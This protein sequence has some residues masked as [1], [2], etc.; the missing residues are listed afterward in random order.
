LTR[1]L[2]ES[3]G[4][5]CKTYLI[6]TI[7]P[8]V[9]AVEETLSTLSY[10]N[11]ANGI[12]NK[13]VT[14]AFMSGAASIS[15]LDKNVIIGE[16]GAA[17]VPSLQSWQE[18]EVRLA[19][20]TAQV[21]EAQQMLAQKHIENKE[22][23]E[24][25]E[26]AD[27]A[28]KVAEQTLEATTQRVTL[29]ETQLEETALRLNRTETVLNETTVLL[30][31]KH[32]SLV[33]KREDEIA[34][35]Q[36]TASYREE[37]MKL[38]QDLSNALTEIDKQ[39]TVLQT[40]LSASNMKQAKDVLARLD[41]HRSKVD[42]LKS[43]ADQS[44]QLR[45]TIHDGIIPF[46][47]SFSAQIKKDLGF[48]K[49]I[50]MDHS[51]TLQQECERIS[52]RLD[53]T[54][55][56]L[57]ESK[58]T[59]NGVSCAL[60]TDVETT[61]AVSKE[62]MSN[63][64]VGFEQMIAQASDDRS[65]RRTKLQETLG[66][67]KDTCHASMDT[68]QSL[69]Q[70]HVGNLHATISSLM[71][72][73]KSRADL[74]NHF[75]HHSKTLTDS[76]DEY[77]RRLEEQN[78]A[79]QLQCKTF[80]QLQKQQTEKSNQMV[81]NIMST[82]EGVV[83]KEAAEMLDLQRH[84]FEQIV[85][86]NTKMQS[87]NRNLSKRLAESFETFKA[88][89]SKVSL[90][91]KDLFDGQE[92]SFAILAEETDSF[93]ATMEGHVENIRTAFDGVAAESK[94]TIDGMHSEDL[95]STAKIV[96]ILSSSMGRHQNEWTVA[97]QGTV[98]SGIEALQDSLVEIVQKVQ[99]DLINNVR[100]DLA[101]GILALEASNVTNVNSSLEKM[102]ADV[103]GGERMIEQHS[104]RNLE[105]AMKMQKSIDDTHASMTESLAEHQQFIQES[106]WMETS[107]DNHNKTV[108]PTI[109]AAT[110][111]V[112]S[113]KNHLNSFAREVIRADEEPA[114]ISKLCLPANNANGIFC[115]DNENGSTC[116]PGSTSIKPNVLKDRPPNSTHESDETSSPSSLAGK[117]PAD[118][119]AY[120]SRLGK[121]PK[122]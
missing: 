19:Y 104:N 67:W 93:S 121:K 28:K 10:A 38:L 48:L 75:S 107:L 89:N 42:S 106:S 55:V 41:A 88:A 35:K 24:R 101:N 99:S 58:A 79:L 16:D 17:N 27:L 98:A 95:S 51:E 47:Q 66:I 52:E 45:A 63:V 87:N 110:E 70:R 11:A 122:A 86:D 85:S 31:S 44:R 59:H 118:K 112:V 61:L 3:L 22:L 117:R 92:R 71:D 18:L 105:I 80:E 116:V 78:N 9:T 13:P 113:S 20:M 68:T 84:S 120:A 15:S 32:Q 74:L 115:D 57:D 37:T 82:L 69:S 5:R 96:Q 4:G 100:T 56:L 49:S 36:G 33:E 40:N 21:D 108:G 102:H 60:R 7:S 43:F 109:L 46:F 14:T 97:V 103:V 81:Q 64:L 62:N 29:L 2:Q 94:D 77:I 65:S 53:R 90:H 73:S 6:A 119:T 34:Y 114:P 30:Q 23:L 39:Q 1:I 72:D 25:A 50:S 76:K 12:M 54:V 26:Q 91:A 83:E 8:S 111:T